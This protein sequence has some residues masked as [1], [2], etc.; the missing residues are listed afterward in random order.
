MQ[1]SDNPYPWLNINDERRNISDG[2]IFTNWQFRQ[3]I[4]NC[5]RREVF[6]RYSLLDHPILRMKKKLIN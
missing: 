1:E 3:L 6:T 5:Y 4:F 2:D